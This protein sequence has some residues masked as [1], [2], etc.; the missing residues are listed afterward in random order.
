M[1]QAETRF[2]PSILN[3]MAKRQ[4]AGTDDIWPLPE[5][6]NIADVCCDRWADTQPNRVALIDVRDNASP[7]HWTYAELLR[8]ATKLAHYFKSHQIVEGDRIALLLPQGPEVLIA[9][10]AAYRIGAIIL[11]L[12]TLFGPDALA[13]RLH[14]SGTKLTITGAGSLNKLLPILPDLP[15]LEQILVCGLNDKDKDKQEQTVSIRNFWSELKHMPDTSLAALSGPDDPA[16]LIYTSGTTGNPKGVL[17]AHRFLLGHLPNIEISHQ[18]FPRA[19]DKG[20]TPADW[21]W[22]G[23]LMDL[24]LPCLYYGV[25]LVSYRQLKFD[26]E[27]TFQ[28]IADHQ[29]R[30]MF[31]P[32]TCLLYTSPSP[33]DLSTS[34]MPSSA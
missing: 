3:Q 12:F 21:A 14:D 5:M 19:G 10:F 16:M 13:Y 9:H 11:P 34:R 25:P 15:E 7:K 26:P 6:F 31:L 33:R 23:G 28:F 17:H 27:A 32:P 2:A 4:E 24:A 18:G 1:I 29:I 30:N 8:A 20:W 22:I